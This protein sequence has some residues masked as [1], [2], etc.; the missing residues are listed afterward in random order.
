MPLKTVNPLKS[1]SAWWPEICNLFQKCLLNWLKAKPSVYTKED[2]PDHHSPKSFKTFFCKEKRGTSQVTLK[3]LEKKAILAY[4]LAGPTS[5]SFTSMLKEA[6][7]DH[8]S[9][10]SLKNFF[11]KKKEGQT[12]LYSIP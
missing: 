4:S 8:H 12:M 6:Q 9:P 2:Q 3:S 5:A 7:P 10:K 11:A 1:K